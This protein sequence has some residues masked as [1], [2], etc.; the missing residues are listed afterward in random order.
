MAIQNTKRMLVMTSNNKNNNEIK[1][2]NE[3]NESETL[4]L[5]IYMNQIK[6]E[7]LHCVDLIETRNNN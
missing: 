7:F 2:N 6:S 1:R 4:T 5:C 3:I